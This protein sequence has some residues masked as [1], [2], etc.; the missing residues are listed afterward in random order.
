MDKDTLMYRQ[1]TDGNGELKLKKDKG[2]EHHLTFTR[3]SGTEIG[4]YLTHRVV[5]TVGATGVILGEE[6]TSVLQEFNCVHTIKAI[7]LDNTSTD[8]GRE[9]GLV[10]AVEKQIGKNLH[11]IG[12][13]LHQNE[14][15]FRAVF[16][17][18]DGIT[19]SPTSFS[20]PLGIL[21]E[22]DC[23]LKMFFTR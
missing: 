6:F 19:K 16:K 20:G 10:S 22:K 12:C 4:T 17:Q 8:T 15:P 13:S 14:L 18:L 11:T 7:L 23:C 5:P 21:C 1:F 9:G 2:H 3:E